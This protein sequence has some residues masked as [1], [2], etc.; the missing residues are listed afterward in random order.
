VGANLPDDSRRGHVDH[1]SR[2]RRA[3][4]LVPSNLLLPMVSTRYTLLRLLAAAV[5]A[6]LMVACRAGQSTAST[7]TPASV[8]FAINCAT[9]HGPTGQGV[10][11]FPRLVGTANILDGDYDRTVIT[12]GRLAMPAFGKV[13]TP[14]QI[15]QIVAYVDTF[16]N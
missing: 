14:A 11:V 4:C 1:H 16:G 9:C 13:L 6:L 15:N 5:V 10:G 2:R 7:Q 8:L 12:Q 3:R